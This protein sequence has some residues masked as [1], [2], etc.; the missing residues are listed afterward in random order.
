MQLPNEFLEKMYQVL[1]EGYTLNE[2]Y[3]DM[4]SEDDEDILDIIDPDYVN[5][6]V[7][8]DGEK[9]IYWEEDYNPSAYRMGEKDGEKEA[10]IIKRL[11]EFGVEFDA[12]C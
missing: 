11:E 3:P 1:V 6:M 9:V 8:E 2:A 10:E 7:I 4:F 12:E 5:R